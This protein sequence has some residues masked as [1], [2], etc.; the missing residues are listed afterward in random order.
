MLHLVGGQV[1]VFLVPNDLP[2]LLQAQGQG[3]AG[4]LCRGSRAPVCP[5]LHTSTG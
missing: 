1:E 5:H 3:V 4:Q 2:D